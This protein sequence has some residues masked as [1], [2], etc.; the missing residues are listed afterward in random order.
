MG[1]NNQQQKMEKVVVDKHKVWLILAVGIVILAVAFFILYSPVREGVFG[2]AIQAGNLISTV[3]LTILPNNPLI[4]NATFTYLRG[5]YI[6]Y[7]KNDSRTI[8]ENV[9][10]C[11]TTCPSY[12]VCSRIVGRVT[13][14]ETVPITP[15]TVCNDKLDDDDDGMV[16]C[17]D[18]YDCYINNV[19]NGDISKILLVGKGLGK[20][21]SS[22]IKSANPTTLFTSGTHACNTLFNNPCKEIESFEVNQWR[23]DNSLSCGSLTAKDYNLSKV[24]RAVCGTVSVPGGGTPLPTPGGS[25][26]GGVVIR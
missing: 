4:S 19:C 13:S 8:T 7:V 25:S 22:E 14:I 26:G 12:T 18:V 17:N 3:S 2:K 24:Y 11:N 9:C 1:R 10:L 16:D 5:K 20:V 23:V 6:L 15:E 21:N